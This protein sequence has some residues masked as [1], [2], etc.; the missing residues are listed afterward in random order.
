MTY[1]MSERY[2][3]YLLSNKCEDAMDLAR[4]YVN[5]AHVLLTCPCAV[6]K[7]NAKI[8]FHH[9]DEIIHWHVSTWELAWQADPWYKGVSRSIKITRDDALEILAEIRNKQPAVLN[10]LVMLPQPIAEEIAPE[11]TYVNE[12]IALL[13]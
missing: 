11:I 10:M 13:K 3:V 12:L 7:Y 2:T 6:D 5:D 4:R 1:E 8:I 9:G